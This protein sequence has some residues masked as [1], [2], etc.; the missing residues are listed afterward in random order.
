M[1]ECG[2]L[3][4]RKTSDYLII[5]KTAYMR[6]AILTLLPVLISVTFL[7]EEWKADAANAK[8]EFSVKGLFGTVHG[9]FSGLKCAI[10]FDEHDLAGSSITASVDASTVSTGI[11]LRNHHLR[12]E[13]QWLNVKKYPEIAFRSKKIVKTGN[14]L[15]ADGELVIKGITRQI[16]IPFTFSPNGSNAGVFKGD[17]TIRREDYSVGKPGGS[18]GDTITIHLEVPVTK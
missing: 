14:G 5:A 4:L 9:H 1:R 3:F 13:E 7:A 11:G 12:E 8:I 2:S 6:Q 17:F 10:R 18:V 16:Q 15:R